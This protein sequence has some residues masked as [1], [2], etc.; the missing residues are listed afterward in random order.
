MVTDALTAKDI[1]K[2]KEQK[3][4]LATSDKSVVAEPKKRGGRTKKN[5]E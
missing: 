3:S 5:A 1:S 2:L 4:V